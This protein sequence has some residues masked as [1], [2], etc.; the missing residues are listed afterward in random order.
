LHQKL[1]LTFILE[2]YL[3]TIE[4]DSSYKAEKQLYLNEF[5]DLEVD[6][7]AH[8]DRFPSFCEIDC[9]EVLKKQFQLEEEASPH[10]LFDPHD[11]T[12]LFAVDGTFERPEF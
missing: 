5:E 8:M 7:Y 2:Q 1:I 6:K 11:E 10:L 3:L 12:S 4:E 9:D